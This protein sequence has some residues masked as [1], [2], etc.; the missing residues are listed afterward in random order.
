[1]DTVRKF[2]YIIAGAIMIFVAGGVGSALLIFIFGASWV[3]FAPLFASF[4]LIVVFILYEWLRPDIH[5]LPSDWDANS[6]DF[7]DVSRD[8]PKEMVAFIRNKVRCYEEKIDPANLNDYFRHYQ[9]L[10][11]LLTE[12]RWQNRDQAG[13]DADFKDLLKY[14]DELRSSLYA[15]TQS[16]AKKEDEDRDLRMRWWIGISLTVIALVAVAL[17]FPSLS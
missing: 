16:I 14:F 10:L 3:I 4:V 13:N 6:R 17:S 9:E 5:R 12:D 1:L 15:I 8:K 11:G 2:T 7:D